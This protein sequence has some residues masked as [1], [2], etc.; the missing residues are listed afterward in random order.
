[1]GVGGGVGL[2]VLTRVSGSSKYMTP[3]SSQRMYPVPSL[4]ARH[5][6]EKI[7]C[8]DHISSLSGVVAERESVCRVRG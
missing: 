5:S 4:L 7:C 2:R 1:M 3:S 6:I 8:S